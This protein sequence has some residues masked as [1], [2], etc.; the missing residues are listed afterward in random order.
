MPEYREITI[1]DIAR[2]LAISPATVSRALNNHPAVKKAT[3]KKIQD[4]ARQLGYRSNTFASNLR[5]KN[6]HTIGVIVPRLSSYFMSTVIAGMEQVARAEGYNLIISQSS[7]SMIKEADNVDTMFNSR[8]DGLL[9]SLS[10]ETDT[11]AHFEPFF[12]KGIPLIFFDRIREHKQ[13]MGIVIDNQ[14][15]AYDATKHLLDNGYRRIMHIGGNPISHVYAE[16]VKGY[17]KALG[18]YKIP[19]DPKLVLTRNMSEQAGVDAAEH[20]LKMKPRPDAVFSANDACAIY[21][22]LTLKK[23]G[24]RI[25]EDIAFAGFNND[26]MSKVVEPG[27][28]TIDYPGYAMGEAAA[29]QLINQLTGIS[30]M[31]ATNIIILRS[32]LIIRGSS[33]KKKRKS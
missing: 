32:E 8:V 6:T 9:V 3:R 27:L 20:I 15:A 18:D 17:K 4:L 16:R 30:V 19:V 12:K 1:Y 33:A 22:M 26:P 11:L 28:T 23:A 21:C 31:Q 14:K 29:T 5:K 13:C 24:L 10:Y 25:P 2:E 7:E